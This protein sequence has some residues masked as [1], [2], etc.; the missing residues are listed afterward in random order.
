M[1]IAVLILSAAALSGCAMSAK[2]LAKSD[3]EMTLYSQKTP[4]QW[5]TCTAETMNGPVELRNDGTAW[6][7]LRSNGYQ[8]PTARWDFT[9]QPEGGS[10]AELRATISVNTGDERVKACA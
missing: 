8:I 4:Q 10:K 6:W 7:V 9:P 1:R 5:A 2:G 3:V